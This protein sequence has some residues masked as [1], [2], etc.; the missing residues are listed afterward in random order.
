MVTHHIPQVVGLVP[1]VHQAVCACLDVVGVPAQVHK[2]LLFRLLLGTHARIWSTQRAAA[3]AAAEE[4]EE[5]EEEEE[6]RRRIRMQG[7]DWWAT[8]CST[9]HQP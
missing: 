3:A 4:E 9:L 7:I 5:E 2:L 8:R 6:R 1:G